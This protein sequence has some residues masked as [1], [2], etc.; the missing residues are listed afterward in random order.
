M[1]LGLIDPAVMTGVS[2]GNAWV[3]VAVDM[4]GFKVQVVG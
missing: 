3:T 1:V 2:K 4:V